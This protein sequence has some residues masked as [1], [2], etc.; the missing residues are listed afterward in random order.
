MK[1]QL[2]RKPKKTT[3]EVVE[4]EVSVRKRGRKSEAEL[5]RALP[6][7]DVLDDKERDFFDGMG[8]SNGE[9]IENPFV[10]LRNLITEDGI[11]VKTVLTSDQV[12][13]MH[14]LD[15]MEELLGEDA[16]ALQMLRRFKQ[17]Y[18]KFIINKDGLSRKQF[19]E[20]LHK[21]AEKAEQARERQ[22]L[23]NVLPAV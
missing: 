19:I 11:D 22:Q 13:H 8:D 7:E 18:M 20:A 4:T 21:G 1:R 6:P 2:K 10:E 23:K 5:A 16:Q 3:V 14:K 15:M 12:L 9:K 17:T